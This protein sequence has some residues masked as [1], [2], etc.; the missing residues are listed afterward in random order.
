MV[1]GILKR[2][3]YLPTLPIE[4]FSSAI[5]QEVL[6][7]SL[8][9]QGTRSQPQQ[10]Q[11]RVAST[12][13]VTDWDDGTGSS[14]GSSCF[15]TAM[16]LGIDSSSSSSRVSSSSCGCSRPAM[17]LEGSSQKPSEVGYCMI[18]RG[19]AQTPAAHAFPTADSMSQA[20]SAA[21]RQQPMLQP[22]Q[23]QPLQAQA[24]GCSRPTWTWSSSSS[25]GS[26]SSASSVQG[27]EGTSGSSSLAQPG[28]ILS[29]ELQSCRSCSTW[30]A[31]TGYTYF[32]GVLDALANDLQI[33]EPHTLLSGA[34]SGSLIAVFAKCGL[35]IHT[36]L[37]LTRKFSQDC[38]SKGVKGRL[39]VVLRSY[40][41]E[42]LPHNAHELC[43]GI[44]FL[45]VTKVW[46]SI[47]TRLFSSFPTRSDLI[48]A[49]LASCHLPAL[50]DGSL[51]K[52]FMGRL[53]ID[54]GLLSVVTPPPDA[55]HTVVVCRRG[56]RR[57]PSSS[58]EVVPCGV[59]SVL[60]EP[61]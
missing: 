59:D 56:V 52:K 12:Q 18:Q 38:A 5:E 33:L 14:T 19:V 31:A 1:S 53:H 21:P 17:V 7:H 46:P 28:C 34:S 9:A 16:T 15:D 61:V 55:A 43:D 2:C 26:V 50:S 37:E 24:F 41:E 51:T 35:P 60:L 29:I 30:L 10:D 48:D 32:V 3:L 23:L 58:A 4:C 13:A 47:R 27:E 20:V 36:V 25:S 44:T 8:G 40:L 22:S 49:V 11:L 6:Q 54:G 42:Y 45:A 39:G 57:P